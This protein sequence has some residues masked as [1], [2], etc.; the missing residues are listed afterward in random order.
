MGS[1]KSAPLIGAGVAV[2]IVVIG[3]VVAYFAFRDDRPKVVLMGDSITYISAPAFKKE[4]KGSYELVVSGTPKRRADE[5]VEDAAVL[6]ATHPDAVVVN[7]GTNDVL[8]GRP[9]QSAADALEKIGKT[10]ADAECV[11]LVTVNENMFNAE[12][13]SLGPDAKALNQEILAM[14]EKH[15]WG[16][17]RW[18]EIVR[19]YLAEG[20]KQGHL[21]VDTVHP[22]PV[23]RKLL[24]DA[25]GKALASCLG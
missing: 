8:Q 20:E 22:R 14:A 19:R 23:G 15:G 11:V 9:P 1:S 25:Y 3:G 6:D 12:R 2:V 7:L 21:S 5:R 18:D 17:V 13:A 4:L 16:V 10:F 24:A